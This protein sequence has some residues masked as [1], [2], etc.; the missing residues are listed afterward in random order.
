[1]ALASHLA[2][3]SAPAIFLGFPF[4]SQSYQGDEFAFGQ[5]AMRQPGIDPDIEMAGVALFR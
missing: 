1:M 2:E 5:L 3:V 4:L